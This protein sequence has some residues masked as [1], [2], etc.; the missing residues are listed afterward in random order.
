[1]G[2]FRIKHVDFE[3]KFSAIRGGCDT[4][5]INEWK[6]DTRLTEP[7]WQNRYEYEAEIISQSL[8]SLKCK[9]ILEIGSGPG[10]LS[11]LIQAKLGHE[12]E[13]HLV[14][15]PYAKEYFNSHNY[16][17]KF[18]V[19]DISLD[20]DTTD[21]LPSYDVIICND[22]LEHLLAPSNVV[23]KIHS[24]L[25]D[26]SKLIISVPNWRMAHQFIYRGLW[27]YDNFIYFMYI[28]DIAIDCVYPSILQTPFYPKLDSESEM[29]DDLIQSWNF[30]FECSKKP[31]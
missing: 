3:Q 28:H 31:V 2:I 25:H 8:S 17:G 5:D 18:F 13:Y 4:L 27:D 1:M 14:D 11:Q 16:K 10:V 20:M 30:Y 26:K 12:I 6:D 24:L 15:K 9:S 22:T 19:K 23:K 29:P 7:G 21:L